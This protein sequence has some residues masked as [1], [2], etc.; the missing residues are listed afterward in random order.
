MVAPTRAALK[1]R[2]RDYLATY[3]GIGTDCTA[4][5][6]IASFPAYEV[7]IFGLQSRRSGRRN[8]N[9]YGI[10]VFIYVSTFPDATSTVDLFAA[11]T[12]AEN[13]IDPLAEFIAD[14]PTLYLAGKTPPVLTADGD[15]IVTCTGVGELVINAT[16][17]M[18]FALDFSVTIGQ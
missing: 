6:T 18:G 12:T 9:T 5:A 7:Q 10:R 16:T 1:Q 4:S 15:H 17:Y 2:I 13:W 11:K 8:V 14:N 3:V